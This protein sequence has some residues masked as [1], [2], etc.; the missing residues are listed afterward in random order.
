MAKFLEK[1][2]LRARIKDL[3]HQAD[4]IIF[5]INPIKDGDVRDELIQALKHIQVALNYSKEQE[6]QAIESAIAKAEA[7]VEEG[8]N[9][10]NGER[11]AH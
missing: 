11:Y 4:A 8:P 3:H 1:H 7:K 2:I 6:E 9:P 10:A 5:V